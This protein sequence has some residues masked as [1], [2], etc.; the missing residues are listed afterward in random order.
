MQDTP[1]KVR[2]I[3]SMSSIPV[4]EN[5]GRERSQ[6]S[7]QTVNV[8]KASLD[9]ARHIRKN[10]FDAIVMSGR[11]SN[12]SA[13]LLIESWKNLYPIDKMPRIFL[14]GQEGNEILY[15]D[16][17]GLEY[18]DRLSQV[19]ELLERKFSALSSMKRRSI[20]YVDEFAATGSKYKQINTMLQWLGFSKMSFAFLFARYPE[21]LGGNAFVGSED[22]H[23]T[24]F[25]YVFT[26]KMQGFDQADWQNRRTPEDIKDEFAR[27]MDDFI[28]AIQV[29]R[30]S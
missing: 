29:L 28:E 23:M 2:Y 5:F 13:S 22:I 17:P 1:Q 20:C 18:H 6:F 16:M 4:R 21:R 24:D 12:I 14:L 19:H 8:A 25:M 30:Y 11:S 3:Y 26:K 15:K 9:L 7:H 27:Q 10:N